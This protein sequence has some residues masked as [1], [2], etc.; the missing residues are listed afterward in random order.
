MECAEVETVSGLARRSCSGD[1]AKRRWAW[2]MV[3]WGWPQAEGVLGSDEAGGAKEGLAGGYASREAT[4]A[5]AMASSEAQEGQG[6]RLK[7]GGLEQAG[8]R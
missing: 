6:L 2:Q 7:R 1:R 3:Q 8:L 4:G 5:R